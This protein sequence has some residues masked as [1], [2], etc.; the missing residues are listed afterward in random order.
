MFDGACGA[1][2]RKDFHFFFCSQE[3]SLSKGR[4]CMFEI[5]KSTE[6]RAWERSEIVTNQKDTQ[7]KAREKKNLDG[8]YYLKKAIHPSNCPFAILVKNCFLCSKTVG[9]FA[10]HRTF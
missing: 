1:P 10:V 3:N 5:K 9:T 7:H 2:E 6:K 8:H 4:N